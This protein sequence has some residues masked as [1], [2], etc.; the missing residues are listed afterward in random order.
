MTAKK[1]SI[2]GIKEF[3]DGT[4]KGIIVLGI[5]AISFFCVRILDEYDTDK[6]RTRKMELDINTIK[7]ELQYIKKYMQIEQVSNKPTPSN[8]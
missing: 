6:E 8:I 4:Y 7:I 3:F 1:T 2:S 5:G